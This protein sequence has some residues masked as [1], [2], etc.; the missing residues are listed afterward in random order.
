MTTTLD[1]KTIAR[2]RVVV[3]RLSRRLRHQ[4]GT[5]ITSSQMSAMG[6]LD[7]LGPMALRDL[8]G[9]EQI[10]PSTLTRIV[11]SLEDGG[12][13]ERRPDPNH[14][15]VAQVGLTPA[16]RALLEQSRRRSSE[17]LAARVAGL[18]PEEQDALATALPVLEK[19]MGDE[20]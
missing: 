3:M 5:G 2:L 17:H 12:K 14:R 8:A 10:A 4:A 15:R 9:V 7:R 1:L 18:S 16:G 19:L 20:A 13:L 11:A 6:T